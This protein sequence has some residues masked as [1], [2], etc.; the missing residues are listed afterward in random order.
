MGKS[1]KKRGKRFLKE[2]GV[3]MNLK[4]KVVAITGGGGGIGRVA[5]NVFAKN[6]A[7]VA[8]LELNEQGGLE[9]EAE[10]KAA[11]GNALF[12]K[13]DVSSEESVKAAFAKIEE[14]FGTLDALYNN[15][16]VFLGG[17]DTNL[18]DVSYDIWK[19]VLAINLDS[20]YLCSKYAIAI[21]KKK[22]GAIINTASSAGV[23]GVP[24][25]AAYTATKG[26]TVSLTR[27]MAVECGKYGIRTNCIAPAAIQTAMVKQSNLNDPDFDNDFFI[28][29]ITPS[30]RWGKPEEVANLACFLASDEAAYINGAIIPADGGITINGNVNKM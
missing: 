28:R 4:G 3:I 21:M 24:G 1:L 26:A 25:C 9:T 5:S 16:S 29:Q 23:V 20:V 15:A 2:K 7:T 22:G 18:E 19:K 13:T 27:A 14:T 8:I 6:G 17:R 30:G 11:G 12:I 10:I